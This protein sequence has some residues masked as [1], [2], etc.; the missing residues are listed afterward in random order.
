MG[1]IG[2]ATKW[3]TGGSNDERAP[4]APGLAK[5]LWLLLDNE[6][7]GRYEV[8]DN[9]STNQ[10]VVRSNDDP[11][12]FAA[13]DKEGDS[14]WIAHFSRVA[15][16]PFRASVLA[17]DDD[18]E[19]VPAPPPTWLEQDPD[20]DES[21]FRRAPQSCDFRRLAQLTLMQRPLGEEPAKR[22]IR[23]TFTPDLPAD[24]VTVT[25]QGHREWR[26]AFTIRQ[27]FSRLCPTIWTHET[28]KDVRAAADAI[29][30]TP[31]RNGLPNSHFDVPKERK[32]T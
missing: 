10:I 20:Y 17:A 6:T 1:W 3:I 24:K 5:A 14:K 11:A 19:F 31:V 29:R 28:P 4:L 2:R 8:R 9:K 7:E 22:A 16:A 23:F 25:V 12:Q 21:G 15:G 18:P 13:I 30:F 26:G 32:S 27:R